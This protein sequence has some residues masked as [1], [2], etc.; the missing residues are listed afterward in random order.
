M[1]VYM[2]VLVYG[3]VHVCTY[4][5]MYTCVSMGV[6][7]HV[8][9]WVPVYMCVCG[10]QGLTLAVFFRKPQTYLGW[11]LT[12]LE[13]LATRQVEGSAFLP[14]QCWHHEYASLYLTFECGFWGTKGLMLALI[15]LLAET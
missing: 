5:C 10:S 6:C 13:Y 14:R 9:L 2:G 4:V 8:C 1:H 15:T 3:C 12:S 7:V 11:T